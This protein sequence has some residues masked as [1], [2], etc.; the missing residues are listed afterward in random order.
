MARRPRRPID[1]HEFDD[2]L[3]NYNSPPYSDE[4]E[5]VLSE[6]KVQEMEIHPFFQV[7][8]A[9]TV[10]QTIRD[11]AKQDLFCALIVENDRLLGIFSERDVLTRVGDAFENMQ[12]RPVSELMTSNP[13]TVY[14][15]DPPAKVLNLMAEGG[16]RHIPVLDVDEYPVGILGPRRI[17]RLLNEQFA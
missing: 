10:G 5:R 8:P 6:T 9:T 11:M 17:I 16:F 2:P 3:S 13:V 7:T 15:T 14:I 1:P 4:F 12:D